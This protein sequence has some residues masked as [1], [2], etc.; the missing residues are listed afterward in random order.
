MG[1][2]VMGY[3]GNIAVFQDGKTVSRERRIKCK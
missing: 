2:A 1:N 3:H